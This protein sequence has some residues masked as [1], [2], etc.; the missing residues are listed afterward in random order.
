MA[1]SDYPLKALRAFESAARHLSFVLAADELHVTPA[2]VSHQ[3]KRLEEYLGIQLFQRLPRGLLLSEIGQQ[4]FVQLRSVFLSLD[5]AMELVLEDDS[6]GTLTI[7]VAPVFA[8]K[9]LVPRLQRFEELYPQIDLRISSTL[10]MIDFQRHSFD[11]AVRLGHGDYPG[12]VA[13]KLFEESVTPMCSPHILT[14]DRPLVEPQDLQGQV[15]LHDESLALD[16]DAPD[17][18]SWLQAANVETVNASHGTRFDQPD[19]ALQAA[20]DGAGVVLGRRHLASNDIA[21]GRLVAP[22]ELSL[23]LGSNFYLVYPDARARKKKIVI[24]QEWLIEEIG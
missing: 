20:I 3:V 18:R 17:W 23:P 8:T 13:I 12:L 9:W 24:L 19:Q 7:S 22:F 11:A 5:K 1:R 10:A 21:A 6:H 15:L 2:A 4:L 14:G 16:L